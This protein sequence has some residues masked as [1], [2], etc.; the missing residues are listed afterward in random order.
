MIPR[1]T[2]WGSRA[3]D[4]APY[5]STPSQRNTWEINQ[6]MSFSNWLTDSEC[7]PSSLTRR[8]VYWRR[9]R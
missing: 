3:N 1:T 9:R 4:L 6:S 7:R 8:S 2:L 5:E